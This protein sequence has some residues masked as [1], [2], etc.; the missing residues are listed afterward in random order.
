MKA[1]PVLLA[2]IPLVLVAGAAGEHLIGHRV[3]EHMPGEKPPVWLELVL[4]GLPGG[5]EAVFRWELP[6]NP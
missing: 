2:V 5:Q 1:E 4:K 3:G 6:Q